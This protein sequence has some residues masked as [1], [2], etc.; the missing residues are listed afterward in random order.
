MVI[1]TIF[2]YL[3]SD[4]FFKELESKG[5][6]HTMENI[7]VCLACND[8]LPRKCGRESVE[9]RALKKAAFL[10]LKEVGEPNPEYEFNYCDVYSPKLRIII[11]CGNTGADKILEDLFRWNMADEVWVLDYPNKDGNAELTKL[12]RRI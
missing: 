12:K 7:H 5:V 4:S 10:M 1:Y 2:P 9:H 11:E 8:G 6:I 3:V